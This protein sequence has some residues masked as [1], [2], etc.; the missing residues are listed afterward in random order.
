M[1]HA[2]VFFSALI[3]ATFAFA[4]DPQFHAAGVMCESCEVRLQPTRISTCHDCDAVWA[5]FNGDGLDDVLHQNQ[6]QLNLGGKLAPEI[7]VDTISPDTTDSGERVI[8]AADFNGDHF[9]DV[10]VDDFHTKR[11]MLGDGTGQFSIVLPMPESR[12]DVVQ[13]GDFTGDGRPDVLTLDIHTREFLIYRNL[14]DGT[15]ALHQALPWPSLTL[16]ITHSDPITVADI[17]GDGRADLIVASPN[18]INFFFAQPDGKFVQEERYTRGDV[19]CI[20]AGDL[21]ADGK[22]DLV[23]QMANYPDVRLTALFGDGTGHFPETAD[24]SI[25]DII[26]GGKRVETDPQSMIVGDFVPGGG[27]EIAV[28]EPQGD[29]V[30]IAMQAGRLVE[31]ARTSLEV[32]LPLVK[33]VRFRSFKPELIVTGTIPNPRHDEAWTLDATGML[34]APEKHPTRGRALG[35]GTNFVDGQYEVS[36]QSDCPIAGFNSF[37]FHREGIFVDFVTG[38]VIARADAVYTDGAINVTFT[39]RDGEAVRVLDGSLAPTADGRLT[40]KFFESGKTP[41]G[42]WQIHDVTAVLQ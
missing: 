7:T 31:V 25:P 6:M 13:M 4:S 30:V 9:A 8:F 18:H 3:A 15:F 35:R 32:Y 12:G 40:G 21:N 33:T 42:K 29:V 24:I 39:L 16:L 10:V 19:A 20:Q 41:C 22:R 28:S 1:T 38:G 5:D 26:I 23:L 2:V 14:G 27:E 36:V 34:G 11:L 17:N 37:T